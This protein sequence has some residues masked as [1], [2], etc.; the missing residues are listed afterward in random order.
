MAKDKLSDTFVQLVSIPSPS[1]QELAVAEYI[2]DYLAKAGIKSYFDDSGK[3]NDSNSGNLIAKIPGKGAS[4]VFV[5][6][7]DTV[8]DGDE[9]IQPVVKGETILSDGKS[10]L[11]VDNKAAVACLVEALKEIK[12]IKNHPA[13]TAVFSTREENGTMGVEYVSLNKE[14]DL[15]FVIDAALT[16]GAFVNKALGQI[17]FSIELYGK[18]AHAALAPEK[19]INAIMAASLIVS[20][21]KLGKEGDGSTVNI[22]RI[23]GGSVVNVI[24]KKAVISGEVRAY[25]YAEM[26]AKLA[27]IE[28]TVK[29]VCKKTGCT[30]KLVKKGKEGAPPLHVHPNKSIVALAKASS[31]A[32]G[33]KF[34][35]M[36]LSASGE[37]NVL[38]SKG[39]TVLELCRGGKAPHSVGESITVGELSTLKKVIIEIVKNA[40]NMPA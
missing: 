25:N 6:H 21:T 33:L 15:I 19:G 29:S 12:K 5:A 17:P 20:K 34:E 2:K 10:I 38:D 40:N 30:Y 14:K 28:K 35:L 1:G 9:P 16:S 37:A 24:P 23:R 7:I 11:G 32:A 36:S 39:F 22:S 18:E 31:I 26:H 8:E 3:L 13:V 27:A 4:I